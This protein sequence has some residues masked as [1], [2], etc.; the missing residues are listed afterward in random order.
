M[1]EAVDRELMRTRLALDE[2]RY[3]DVIERSDAS[4][5]GSASDMTPQQRSS[6]LV[7]RAAARGETWDV[8]G[9]LADAEEAK[10]FFFSEYSR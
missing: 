4:L 9:A 8:A 10:G 2:Q 5:E 1:T 3:L 7:M 6:M